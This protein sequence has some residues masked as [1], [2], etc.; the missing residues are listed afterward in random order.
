MKKTKLIFDTGY[1]LAMMSMLSLF[2]FTGCSAFPN[3]ASTSPLQQQ[4]QTDSVMIGAVG[5]SIYNVITGAKKIKAE[6]IKMTNDTTQS[7]KSIVVDVKGNFIPLVQF[8]LSNPK[9]YSG[10]TAVYGQFMPC[11]KLTFIKKKEKCVLY[12]DFGL[13]K[14]NV[15]DDKGRVIKAFDLS[16]N[17]MLRIAN[18]LFPNNDLFKKQM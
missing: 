18:M 10:N 16:T 1:R 3:N 17:D 9:I 2:V 8:V 13:K 12:F 6:E 7:T 15:C 11:F 5:D 4:A 14:W